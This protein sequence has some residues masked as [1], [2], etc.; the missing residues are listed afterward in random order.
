MLKTF[1]KIA[2]I[3]TVI[4]SSVL[5]GQKIRSRIADQQPESDR[6]EVDLPAPVEIAP[7]TVGE[8][9]LRR[10]ISGTLVA[11]SAFTVAPKIAGRVVRL[12]VDL[13]DPVTKG[14]VVALLDDA[15]HVQAVAQ[16][17]ADQAV[18]TAQ[19]A[20]ATG[21]LSIAERT[22]NRVRSLHEKDMA[23]EF[24]Y[25]TAKSDHVTR[26]AQ[27]EV[28]KARVKRAEASVEAARIRLGYTRVVA[29]WGDG[30]DERV[31]AERFVDAGETVSANAPLYRVVEL[32]PIEGLVFVPEREYA[33]LRTG[34]AVNLQT[35]AYPGETFKGTIERIAP[36]FREASRQARV[37][38]KIENE[39]QALKPGMFIRATI[40]LDRV[41]DAT[42]VPFDALTERN[43]I[44]GVFV[45]HETEQTVIWRPCAIGITEGKRLQVTPEDGKPLVGRVV[46]LGQHLLDDGGEVTYSERSTDAA[47]SAEPSGTGQ[48]GNSETDRA[49]VTSPE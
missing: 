20:E 41:A 2:L 8:L 44:S 11:S 12:D 46:T 4:G 36:I 6:S 48:L 38:L 26:L 21:G 45:L 15:E 37:Q 33:R 35:D 47:S 17:K 31:V 22:L 10:T 30:D 34:Q 24:E 23:A 3:A 18:A 13:A 14:Q 27:V 25:D 16:A 19:L 7:I 5:I 43:G 32:D 29:D 49:G 42:I 28:A 40:E 1:L 9:V 39:S